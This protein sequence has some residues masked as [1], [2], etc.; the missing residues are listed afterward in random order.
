MPPRYRKPIRPDHSVDAA[1]E[2]RRRNLTEVGALSY[3]VERLAGTVEI[4]FQDIRMSLD[5]IAEA[6]KEIRDVSKRVTTLEMKAIDLRSD[7]EKLKSHVFGP[8][9]KPT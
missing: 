7:V 3:K 1:E 9:R 8:N 2:D 5:H 6:L 4:G